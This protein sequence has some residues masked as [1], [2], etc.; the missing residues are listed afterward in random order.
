MKNLIRKSILIGFGAASLTK[1]RAEKLV[2]QFVK[3]KAITSK[4]ANAII[5]AV[6]KEIVKQNKRLQQFGKAKGA[7]LR[8][9]AI[10]ISAELE[11]LG[12]AQAKKVLKLAEKGLK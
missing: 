4:D 5:N 9:R 1:S 3:K 6:I 2:R 12:R 8:K 11:K 7:E 10:K